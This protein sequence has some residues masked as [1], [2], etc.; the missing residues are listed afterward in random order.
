MSDQNGRAIRVAMLEDDASYIETLRLVIDTDPKLVFVAGFRSPIRFLNALEE[1][2]IDVLL[3]DINLPKLAGTECIEALK[4]AKAKVRV[5][6]LTVEAKKETVIDAFRKGADGY[7]LKDS[8]PEQV[9][10]AIR[11]VCAEGAPMSPSIAR[12][13]VGMLKR[14]EATS[15]SENT[16]SDAV[17]R[18]TNRE[19]EVLDWLARGLKYAE[20]AERMGVSLDTVKSHLRSIYQK[21]EVR[22][23]SEAMNH[24]FNR[25][26]PVKRL[27]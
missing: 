2:D 19:G 9:G 6:M 14:S 20:I 17:K 18:L 3:L 25:F 5:V 1:L 12:L 13:V 26:E 21:L 7:L 24:A 16:G 22:N 11:E 4:S 23:R 10:A 15:F 27:D 8:S